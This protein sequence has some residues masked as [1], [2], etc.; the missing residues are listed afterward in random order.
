[1]P[2]SKTFL[3]NAFQIL[4][5]MLLICLKV[6]VASTNV[7]PCY[8]NL[9]KPVSYLVVWREPHSPICWGPLGPQ[10]TRW[11]GWW[12]RI[13]PSHCSA[14][15]EEANG[16]IPREISPMLW[17]IPKNLNWDDLADSQLSSERIC[18]DLTSS[19]SL[20][21]FKARTQKARFIYVGPEQRVVTTSC[22][23]WTE[24]GSVPP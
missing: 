9:N 3:L 4:P 18:L 17:A 20:C 12:S 24:R 13:K 7:L 8:P 5:S 16:D 23:D 14:L 1:M 10:S 21:R 2:F 15:C 22:L 19:S 6:N 11:S